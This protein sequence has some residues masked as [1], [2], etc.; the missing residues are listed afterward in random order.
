MLGALTVL[1][2]V[3]TLTP[4]FIFVCTLGYVAVRHQRLFLALFMLLTAF[5]STRD[6]A[7]TLKMTVSGFSVYP[8]DLITVVGGW[9]ALVRLGRWRRLQR[10]TRAAVLVLATL[11]GLGVMT[12]IATY[13]P[14]VGV[15]SWR[16]QLLITALLLYTTTRPRAWTWSD[17]R[18]VIVV[19]AVVVA[20]AS[21]AGILLHGF[22]SST[23]TI[24]VH[25]VL[26]GG[27]PVFAPGS[28]LMLIGL[29]MVV[30]SA[31]KWH[32]RRV[33]MIAL[34][35]AMV[36]LTQNRSVWVA[37]LI[38]GFIWWLTPRLRAR[39]ASGGL[40]GVG[41]TALVFFVAAVT[42]L[43]G[44]SLTALE[45]S[46]SYDG[47]WLWR[48]ARWV[49][50][51]NIPRSAIQWLVGSAFGPTPAS[52]PT[53]FIT[54]AHSLY[55]NAIEMTGF[56]GLAATLIL[57]IVIGRAQLPPATG[58]LGLVIC[59]TFLSFGVAYQLPPW[60]WMLIGILVMARRGLAGEDPTT[61]GG[62]ADQQTGRTTLIPHPSHADL[63]RERY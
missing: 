44:V 11:V 30:F 5:E 58:P 63:T 14:K 28:L 45:K 33:L 49:D 22:G 50:S 18:A 3:L 41:R 37:A 19:P 6:F 39:G 17:L 47:T 29:W 59:V 7:P 9:A 43:V 15:N 56:V 32:T 8:E 46:A 23:S 12:W 25:G 1:T 27:R 10:V 4:V 42:A 62:A 40:G 38:G 57:I 20:V 48:V 31:G 36:L 35:G 13:G 52:T 16:P 26:E 2:E 21:V 54:S 53:L 24:D 51:M 60:A 61:P 34:L 55:V